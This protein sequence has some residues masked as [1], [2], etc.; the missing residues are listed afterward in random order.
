ML[1]AQISDTHVM[2]EGELMSG[3]VDTAP[4]LQ[5]AVAHINAL[6]P[7][8][9]VVLASGDLVDAGR[10]EEYRRLRGIL[11]ALQMPVYLIPGNH[12]ARANL[13]AAFPDHRYLQSG[14]FIQYAIED[15]DLRLIGLDTLVPGAA[16][17]ELCDARLDWLEAK[18]RESDRPALLFMHHPPFSCGIAEF[19]TIALEAGAE[20][21]AAI[22]RSNPQVERVL[23]GHVHRPVQMRW[24]GTLA[25]IGPSTAHYATL[26]L[27]PD[28]ALTFTMDPP[29]IALHHWNGGG[30]VTHLS[31]VGE[32]SGPHAF[33]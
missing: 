2:L 9:D 27:R 24:A 6:V 1:I 10:P 18:L 7:R 20:R 28:V 13:R 16:H 14:D 31:Y 15:H 12:D 23:C 26:D 25:S 4:F 8:P 29:A 5:R 17:G 32:Y 11:A 33:T 30:L 22:V 3:V 21:L 19:D